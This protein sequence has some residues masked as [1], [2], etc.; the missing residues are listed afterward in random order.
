M[1][2]ESAGLDMRL[3]KGPKRH[4]IVFKCSSSCIIQ[5]PELP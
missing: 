4:H 2:R 5:S 1:D 3:I